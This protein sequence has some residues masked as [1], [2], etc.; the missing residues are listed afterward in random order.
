MYEEFFSKMEAK[1]VNVNL[2]IFKRKKDIPEG[3]ALFKK[4]TIRCPH[5]G[6]Q[7]NLICK[8]FDNMIALDEI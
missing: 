8:L 6:G 7:V 4:V 2:S 5:C 1:N 3:V